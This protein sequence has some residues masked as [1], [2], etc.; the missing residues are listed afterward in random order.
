MED[1]MPNNEFVVTAAITREV[2][3]GLEPAI[4]RLKAPRRRSMDTTVKPAYDD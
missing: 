4:H 2:I 1:D 3:A